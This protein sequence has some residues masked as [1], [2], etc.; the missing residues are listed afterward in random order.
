MSIITVQCGN[1]ANYVGAHYWNQQVV[2]LSTIII[3]SYLVPLNPWYYQSYH[4][5]IPFTNL[6]TILV[7]P[8]IEL[9]MKDYKTVINIKHTI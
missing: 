8:C 2:S 3:T 9:L 5:Y 7:D 4:K 1:Y 6:L